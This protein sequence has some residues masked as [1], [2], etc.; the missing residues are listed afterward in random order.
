MVHIQKYSEFG[1]G[2]TSVWCRRAVEGGSPTT[3]VDLV[4]TII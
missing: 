3:P 1:D 2:D 4:T